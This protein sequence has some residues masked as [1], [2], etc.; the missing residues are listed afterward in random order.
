MDQAWKRARKR[1]RKESPTVISLFA[2]C[3]GSS[4]GY[5][6]AGYRELLAVDW[7]KNAVETFKLNFPKVPLFAGDITELSVDEAMKM[8]ELEASGELDILDGS[9]P[10]QG[11]S[12]SGL[13]Q[14]DDPRN[15]LFNE[16]VRLLIGL[17]PKVFIMENVTGMVKGKMKIVF[18]E[19]LTSL[20]KAGYKVKAK[21]LNAAFYGVPQMRRRLIFIGIR[22]DLNIEP[23]FPES[24]TRPITVK[25]AIGWLNPD[26]AGVIGSNK[27]KWLRY[28]RH[29]QMG[30]SVADIHPQKF[31]WSLFKLHPDKPA[32]T[33]CKIMGIGKLATM[34]HY[35]KY[36]MLGVNEVKMI[37][38]F[39]LQFRFVGKAHLAWQQMGNS[40]PPLFMEAIASYVRK[41]F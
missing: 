40:V 27:G 17:K 28:A 26:E 2:G 22:D 24:K 33:V 38:S 15:Q 30:Q 5:A 3:G 6:M 19:V 25:E 21:V 11:F 7:D 35:D 20:K 10:C 13:R 23:S 1:R 8:A 18:T 12:I 39:P 36:R 41:F 9:P 4:L 16:F 34:Y 14:L 32:P 37:C 31:G 29:L